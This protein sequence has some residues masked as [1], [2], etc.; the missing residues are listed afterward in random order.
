MIDQF[1]RLACQARWVGAGSFGLDT[2]IQGL[3]PYM[4]KDSTFVI[5]L[6]REDEKHSTLLQRYGVLRKLYPSLHFGTRTDFHAKYALF[7]MARSH[8]VMVGSANLT[9]SPAHEV[10]LFAKSESM[11]KILA[12]KHDRWFANSNFVQPYTATKLDRNQLRAL[13]SAVVDAK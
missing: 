7:R 10:V 2:S 5:G 8:W 11:F 3:F 1:R 13:S 6:P 9:S 4:P 12:A